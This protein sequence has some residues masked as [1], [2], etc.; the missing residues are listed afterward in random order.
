MYFT[1][2]HYKAFIYVLTTKSHIRTTQVDGIHHS[3]AKIY[4]LE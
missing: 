3:N 4:A 1:F 2:S